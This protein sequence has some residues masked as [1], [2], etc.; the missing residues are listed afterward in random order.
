MPSRNL[1]RKAPSYL[2]PFGNVG[3]TRLKR[4]KTSTAASIRRVLDIEQKACDFNVD[5][6][7]LPHLATNTNIFPVNIMV[8]GTESTQRIGRKIKCK[9]LRMKGVIREQYA[10]VQ[11]PCTV[12]FA[13]VWD[14]RPDPGIIPAY[15]LIFGKTVAGVESSNVYDPLRYDNMSRFKILKEWTQTL[16]A[17]A[18][19]SGGGA[20]KQDY[21]DEYLDLKGK[22][23]TFSDN[24]S[25]STATGACYLVIRGNAVGATD[26]VTIQN[27]CVRFSYFD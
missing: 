8:A 19:D 27:S 1:K 15:N 25:N 7:V 20:F 14:T 21:F 13:V 17:S 18:T 16:N 3:T 6:I 24:G 4:A 26:L 10:D 5:T 12:R 23:T 22:E 2:K 9:S 11:E